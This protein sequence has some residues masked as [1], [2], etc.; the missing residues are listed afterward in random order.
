MSLLRVDSWFYWGSTV[1]L[2]SIVLGATAGVTQ[3]LGPSSWCL[4]S[5]LR[6]LSDTGSVGH[7]CRYVALIRSALLVAFCTGASHCLVLR[8]CWPCLESHVVTVDAVV[9]R[10]GG[11]DDV[12]CCVG[13]LNNVSVSVS[14]VAD[15]KCV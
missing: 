6:R 8:S 12:L 14:R 2:R 1:W 9:V 4:D 10:R 15:A 3:S 13:C 11:S 7:S 5:G